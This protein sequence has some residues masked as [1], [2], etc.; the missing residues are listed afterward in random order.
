MQTDPDYL[1]HGPFIRYMNSP[2][3]R[4]QVLTFKLACELFPDDCSPLEV[5]S[6]SLRFRSRPAYRGALE[7][8]QRKIIADQMRAR[9]AAGP[10]PLPHYNMQSGRYCL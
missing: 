7:L 8:E 2:T 4:A 5:R 1:T 10:C 9:R 3:K 6:L